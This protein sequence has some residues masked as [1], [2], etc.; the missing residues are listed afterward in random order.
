MDSAH[1]LHRHR[2]VFSHWDDRLCLDCIGDAEQ[3]SS[4]VS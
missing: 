3:G 1:E 4:A 2:R